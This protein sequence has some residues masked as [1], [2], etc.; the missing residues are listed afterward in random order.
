MTANKPETVYRAPTFS[1]L[2]S[3]GGLVH[4]HVRG[5]F[6][7]YIYYKGDLKMKIIILLLEDA[8]HLNIITRR[9]KAS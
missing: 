7:G 3:H 5:G 6:L 2:V 1:L 4:E 8:R 9:C